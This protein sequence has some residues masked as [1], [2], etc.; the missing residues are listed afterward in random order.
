MQHLGHT[1]LE[2]TASYIAE[3]EQK[4]K[5]SPGMHPNLTM[6]ENTGLATLQKKKEAVV[7][8]TDKSGRL[9]ID[10]VDNPTSKQTP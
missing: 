10:S 2:T 6:E 7:F 1:L 5:N 8:Q 3:Q 9:S 4:A